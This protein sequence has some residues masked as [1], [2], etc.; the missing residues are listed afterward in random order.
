MA[1]KQESKLIQSLV[2]EVL[3][4]KSSAFEQLYRVHSGRI[5]NLGLKFYE[6]NKSAAE[7]LTK[8]VFV[9][10][11]ENINSYKENI[12]FILWLR[13]LAVTEIRK[14]EIEKTEEVHQVSPADEAVYSLPEEERIVFILHDIEKLTTEETIEI[15]QNSEEEINSWLESARVLV[16]EKLKIESLD[17]LDYKINLITQR[18]EP[19]E[20][21]WDITYNEIHHF[22]TKDLKEDDEREVLNVGDAKVSLGEKLEKLKEEKS[23]KKA[24]FK[25][26]GI[27]ISSKALYTVLLIVLIGVAAFFLFFSVT[28]EY[29]VVNS[30]GSP[31]IKSYKTTVVSNSA[32]LSGGE[33][34]LTDGDSK[35]VLKISG[36]GDIFV[37]PNTTIKREGEKG[38]LTLIKG[39]IKVDKPK[40]SES[41]PL[42]IHSVLLED[43]KPGIYSANVNKNDAIVRSESASVE[44]SVSE[45]EMY[46]LPGYICE[47]RAKGQLGIP[48]SKS[49]K[50]DFINAVNSFAFDNQK[51]RLN[52][53]LLISEKSDALT[54][55]NMLPLTEKEK[56]D[57]V[58]NKLHSLVNM[59][60]N[61]NP[62]QMANLKKGDLMKW[63][64]KI[65]EANKN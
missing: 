52:L 55:F 2:R 8:K 42:E 22:A 44:L 54:L 1:L 10:A 12:T 45:R 63:L 32:L 48:Y 5:Y 23:K 61:I 39:I 56:R 47:I 17:K 62:R 16:M 49:A 38:D 24:F 40:D 25:P 64:N 13:K 9:K 43:F 37:N 27:T 46:L 4:G 29:R 59:P 3:S 60:R 18:P 51:E 21:L 15:T 26:M 33:F 34:L 58:I 57:M 35:A 28:T 30:G 65:E 7:Q 6:H 50:E 19:R 41:L 36:V 20:E 31:T 14:K 53:L 11:F